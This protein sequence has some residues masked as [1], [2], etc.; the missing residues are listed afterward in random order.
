[1][2]ETSMQY[3]FEAQLTTTWTHTSR[4][5]VDH[6]LMSQCHHLQYHYAIRYRNAIIPSAGD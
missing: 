6:M 1:M 5:F 3:Q 2:R 4:M